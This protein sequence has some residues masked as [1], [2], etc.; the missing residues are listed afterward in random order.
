M[1]IERKLLTL[2]QSY[3]KSFSYA[4]FD[5]KRQFHHKSHIRFLIGSSCSG[6]TKEAVSKEERFQ[7]VS[8]EVGVTGKTTASV[9]VP[10]AQEFLSRKDGVIIPGMSIR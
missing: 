8:M 7:R 5:P 9:H 2:G 6:V 10:V 1:N 3:A 4:P